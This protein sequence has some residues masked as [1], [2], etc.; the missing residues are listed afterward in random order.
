M[1]D[2]VGVGGKK[3][4]TILFLARLAASFTKDVRGRVTHGVWPR[5][6]PRSVRTEDH[7]AKRP[8]IRDVGRRG[9]VMH[10]LQ[11]RGSHD[12]L[13]RISDGIDYLHVA[14]ASLALLHFAA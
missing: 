11:R 8:V 7:Q 3:E 2:L 12:P 6:G 13:Q 4:D 14:E 1:H 10:T 9:E 5:A